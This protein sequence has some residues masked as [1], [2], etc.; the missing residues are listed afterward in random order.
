MVDEES[1]AAVEAGGGRVYAVGSGLDQD[2]LVTLVVRAYD[3]R[4]GDLLWEDELNP[5]LDAKIKL[6]SFQITRTQALQTE[7]S[8]SWFHPVFQSSFLVRSLNSQTGEVIWEDEFHAHPEAPDP[9]RARWPLGEGKLL[10]HRF[11]IRI[12]TFDTATGEFLWEDR[13]HP[14]Q[15]ETEASEEE[16]EGV[17]SAPAEEPYTSH[18]L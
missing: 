5:S 13:F 7:Y 16:N 17:L 15:M 18:R 2:G 3:A 11:S 8:G 6:T 4:T 10:D 12:R 9:S 1:A 14:E